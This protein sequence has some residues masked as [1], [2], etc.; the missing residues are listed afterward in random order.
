MVGSTRIV[1]SSLKRVAVETYGRQI[2]NKRISTNNGFQMKECGRCGKAFL[3]DR[4]VNGHQAVSPENTDRVVPDGWAP[5]T[6]G[7]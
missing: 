3:T 6:H 7:R 5:E 2:Y 1:M 4:A